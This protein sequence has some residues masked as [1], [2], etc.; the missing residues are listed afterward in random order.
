[1]RGAGGT[2]GGIGQFFIGLVMIVAGGYLFLNSIH[3]G[4]RGF[5]TF[6]YGGYGLPSGLIFVP[7]MFGVGMIFYNSKNKLG[8][9]LMAVSAVMLVFGVIGNI[10]LR[11]QNMTAFSLIGILVL[12]IGG[13]GLFLRSLK[14]YD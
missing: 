4:N 12:L 9:L 8:W 14:G 11:W 3:V 5:G 10:T 6:Y 2:Q 7:F 13:I 1:M